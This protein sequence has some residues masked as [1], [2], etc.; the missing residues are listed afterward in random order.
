MPFRDLDELLG[1]P[2]KQLPIRGRLLDF[3]DRISKD[4]G[5]LLLRVQQRAKASDGD[6]D[7]ATLVADLLD[8]EGWTAL[9]AEVLGR[10]PEELIAEGLSGQEIAHIFQ[11]L[12]SWHLYGQDAA[13][14]AWESVGNGPAPNRKTR[15]SKAAAPSNRPRGSRAGSTTPA[16]TGK[17]ETAA[18]S[19]GPGSSNGST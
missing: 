9:Q 15:R 2:K 6:T 7:P 12:I 3:P 13:E 11:T 18:A 8:D 16:S 10:S 4:T 5:L 19:P 1:S 17:A 14:A